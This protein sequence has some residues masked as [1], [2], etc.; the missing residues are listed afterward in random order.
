MG[1]LYLDIDPKPEQ[2]ARYGL[3]TGDV[4]SVI[5]TAIGG[6]RVATTVQGLERYPVNVRYARDLRDNPDQIVQ[7]LVS[8]PTGRRSRSA[9]LPTS[10]SRP[11]RR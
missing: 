7:L 1:G 10:A 9:S 8:T 6:L 4:Q 2:I 3:N 11:A 5:E